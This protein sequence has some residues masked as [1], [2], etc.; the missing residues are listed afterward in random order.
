MALWETEAEIGQG[1]PADFP[2][3]P[4]KKFCFLRLLLEILPAKKTLGLP[5]NRVACPSVR[6]Q[7]D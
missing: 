3:R 7:T 5:S 1:R 4:A 6:R 2:C